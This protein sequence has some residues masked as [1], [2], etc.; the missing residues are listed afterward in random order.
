MKA[1]L[2]QGSHFLHHLSSFRARY[3]MVQ[4]GRPFGINWDWLNRQSVVG[5]TEL[6]RHVRPS[7][8][9]SVLVDGRTARGVI[10]PHS[11]NNTS[12]EKK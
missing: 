5:E 6:I 7:D 3:F 10:L 11:R 2:R 9:L 12:Q 8:R 4:H 1:A